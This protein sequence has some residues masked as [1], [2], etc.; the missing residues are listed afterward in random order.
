MIDDKFEARVAEHR[1]KNRQNKSV[2]FLI[3]DDGVLMPN[4]PL[5]AKK[6]R[7]RPY[8]GDI[9]A[10]LEERMKYLAGQPQRRRVINT[11]PPADDEPFDIAKASKDDLIKFAEDE[12][13]E[14]IDPALHLN[15]IRS[16]V[17]KLAGVDPVR[18]QRVLPDG[19]ASD[20]TET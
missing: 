5:I 6:Q 10:T 12:Y 2:P 7:F 14:L 11:A 8:H 16:I 4:V 18:A 9:K 1:G 20:N 3:R 19:G 17:A 15:K 13:G